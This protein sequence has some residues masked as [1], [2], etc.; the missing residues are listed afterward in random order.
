VVATSGLVVGLGAF[1]VEPPPRDHPLEAQR[2]PVA[3][4]ASAAPIQE[5]RTHD[6]QLAAALEQTAEPAQDQQARETAAWLAHEARALATEASP[7]GVPRFAEAIA[8]AREAGDPQGAARLEAE[9][10]ALKLE[11]E[12]RH[13]N[14]VVEKLREGVRVA[15]GSDDPDEAVKEGFGRLARGEVAAV[16]PLLVTLVKRA[17]ASHEI[18]ACTSALRDIALARSVIDEAVA[19]ARDE[20]PYRKLREKLAERELRCR[21]EAGGRAI[22]SGNAAAAELLELGALTRLDGTAPANPHLLYL[23][24]RALET[25]GRPDEARGRYLTA[26]G[27]A[28]WLPNDAAIEILR[29]LA[30]CRAVSRP[31]SERSP[32]GPGWRRLPRARFTVFQETKGT[33]SK[34][35]ARV[36]AARARALSRL[37][38]GDPIRLQATKTV[39]FV[40]ASEESYR[41]SG[42]SPRPWAGGHASWDTLEDGQSS[43]ICVYMPGAGARFDLDDVL[44]H[45]WAHVLV[46]E[47][48]RGA[49]LPSWA[50]EG[51]ATWTERE[52]ERQRFY[53][54]LKRPGVRPVPWPDAITARYDR[55]YQGD[56]PD[57]AY[58]FYAQ[59]LLAFDVVARRVGSAGSALLAAE[60][61]LEYPEFPFKAL[62]FK[63]REDFEK[64]AASVLAGGK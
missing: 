22:R 41:S 56:D 47:H 10:D 6:P 34:I 30:R 32:G 60:R 59:S 57:W 16:G 28:T 21:I 25:D 23:L 18:A 49:P 7:A 52:S 61:V 58:H 44:G 1:F 15:D 38:F 35:A 17:D 19:L 64:L 63:D 2:P 37:A 33:A 54:Y 26:I 14:E 45:E 50:V 9:R 12:R 51:V 42:L 13:V 53:D 4:L 11:L 36:E 20:T 46:E 29:W 8:A 43:T 31:I 5:P 39:V 62:G 55:R 24:G 48:T 3:A 27:T 40:F